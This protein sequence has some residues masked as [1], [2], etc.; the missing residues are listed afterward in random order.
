MNKPFWK[1]TF[2]NTVDGVRTIT[3][4]AMQP[5]PDTDPVASVRLW[6][7]EH[8]QEP[9]SPGADRVMLEDRTRYWFVDRDHAYATLER[10]WEEAMAAVDRGDLLVHLET[11]ETEPVAP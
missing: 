9:V 5:I 10:C 1:R 11:N 6:M 7:E 4:S 3:M 8:W 2:S